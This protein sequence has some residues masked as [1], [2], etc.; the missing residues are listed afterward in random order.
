MHEWKGGLNPVH[1]QFMD[2]STVRASRAKCW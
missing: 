2:Q 1:R